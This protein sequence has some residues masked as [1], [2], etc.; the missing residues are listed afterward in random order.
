MLL[1]L[2][3]ILG[4]TINITSA[5]FGLNPIGT[6]VKSLAY[7]YASRFLKKHNIQKMLN[8]NLASTETKLTWNMNIQ[9]LKWYQICTNVRWRMACR[10]QGRLVNEKKLRSSVI[11]CDFNQAIT[12]MA[13]LRSIN[14]QEK[15]HNREFSVLV[16][17]FMSWFLVFGLVLLLQTCVKK[18]SFE[19]TWKTHTQLTISILIEQRLFLIDRET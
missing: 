14:N 4:T 5:T 16:R 2:F 1:E 17:I 3:S 15:K 9:S 13:I 7:R 18:N 19:E 12:V 10:S 11:H 8:S 6:K